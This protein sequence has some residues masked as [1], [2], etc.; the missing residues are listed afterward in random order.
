MHHR[1]DE[2]TRL[3]LKS[4]ILD[5]NGHPLE[6]VQFTQLEV[7]D[8][9]PGELLKPGIQGPGFQWRTD[10]ESDST[11][12]QLM[13]DWQPDWLPTGFEIKESSAQQPHANGGTTSHLVY[14]DG[15]AMVSVFV[16]TVV[17]ETQ[18]LQGES[19]RGAVNAYSRLDGKR[20]ITAVGEVPL[21]TLKKI[22]ES[23]T[24]SSN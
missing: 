9:I 18:A 6:Q 12:T 16:E 8:E 13:P 5:V 20:Q 17:H 21:P 10:A 1:L 23:V 7:R 4:A 15:L 19:S 2:Q 11:A 24:K 3:L 22:A 14:S